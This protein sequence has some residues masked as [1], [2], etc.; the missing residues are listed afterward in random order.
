MR[1]GEGDA[2]SLRPHKSK[3]GRSQTKGPLG[4]HQVFQS[5][6]SERGSTSTELTAQSKV[7]SGT[8]DPR[9]GSNEDSSTP[10]G[11]SSVLRPPQICQ[12]PCLAIANLLLSR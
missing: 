2:G 6:Y 7:C 8:M 5:S 3:A 11:I 10:Y 1:V 4:L 12:C 9:Q